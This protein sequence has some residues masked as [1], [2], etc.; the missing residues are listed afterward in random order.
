MLLPSKRKPL[1]L[2]LGAMH[3]KCVQCVTWKLTKVSALCMMHCTD[4]GCV[5]QLALVLASTSRTPLHSIML[6]Y[7]CCAS[8]RG[9]HTVTG[10]VTG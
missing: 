6:W 4:S 1:Q 7:T 5:G 3:Q 10:P 9:C 8:S 2:V